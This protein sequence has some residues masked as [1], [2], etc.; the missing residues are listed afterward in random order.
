[1]RTVR[2]WRRQFR[3]GV[4]LAVR[5]MPV[6]VSVHQDSQVNCQS[7]LLPS[8]LISFFRDFSFYHFR[9]FN[10][11]Y[12]IERLARIKMSS[13]FKFSKGLFFQSIFKQDVA[14][15][16][17]KLGITGI[18]THCFVDILY[19]AYPYCRALHKSLQGCYNPLPRPDHIAARF[20]IVQ[21]LDQASLR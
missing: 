11:F 17:V 2:S 8:S 7:L 14:K 12:C 20:Y 4:F 10:K 6:T 21:W 3:A 18:Q 13:N 16:I 9:Y 5:F 19:S 1:M 15:V